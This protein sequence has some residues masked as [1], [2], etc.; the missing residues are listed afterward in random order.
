VHGTFFTS[1]TCS[2]RTYSLLTSVRWWQKGILG[3]RAIVHVLPLAGIG[4][5]HRSAVFVTADESAQSD[6][7]SSRDAVTSAYDP[8]SSLCPGQRADPVTGE[9]LPWLTRPA[10]AEIQAWE[11]GDSTVLEWGAGFSTL[12]WARRAK[13]VITIETDAAWIGQLKRLAVA[14]G[15]ANIEFVS[16]SRRS[17]D[18]AR[19]PE[20][21][22]PD[23]VVIDGLRRLECLKAALNLPRPLTL[24]FDNWQQRGAYMSFAAREI[25]ASFSGQSFPQPGFEHLRHP[26]QT[27]IWR[28]SAFD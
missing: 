19:V 4:S 21:T 2:A 22:V 11:L 24:V 7:R 25:M 10:V 26:W 14:A 1:L 18:Y 28:L 13:R 8:S 16:R 23:V 20:T 12:W 17:A 3:G 15:L 6:Q 5:R 27:A 9:I